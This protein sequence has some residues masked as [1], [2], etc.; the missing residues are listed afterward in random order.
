MNIIR[1]NARTVDFYMARS[2]SARMLKH[3]NNNNSEVVQ[4]VSGEEANVKSKEE[5][6]PKKP[7]L[8]VVP[9]PL[10]KISDRVQHRVHESLANIFS[11]TYP[12]DYKRIHT[13]QLQ[14]VLGSG[15][16]SKVYKVKDT[17]TDE[18]F[19]LKK[20]HKAHVIRQKMCYQVCPL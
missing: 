11:P 9:E 13:L 14:R 12:V 19:A 4:D 17:T 8:P 6:Q 1:L 7:V 5:L 18:E 20:V 16:F 10:Q 2:R 15:S 3:T